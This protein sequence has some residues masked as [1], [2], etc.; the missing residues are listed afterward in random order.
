MNMRVRRVV[1]G[2]GECSNVANRLWLMPTSSTEEVVGD[3][4]GSRCPLS[5][6]STPAEYDIPVSSMACDSAR[7]ALWAAAT[8]P[9]F[10]QHARPSVG[11]VG[12]PSRRAGA[13]NI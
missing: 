4:F 10:S 6:V 8:S 2:Y 3:L 7:V 5:A 9:W 1:A 13:Q 11:A 12:E